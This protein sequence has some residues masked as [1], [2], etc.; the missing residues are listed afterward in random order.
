MNTQTI[1]RRTTW[2]V[3]AALAAALLPWQSAAAEG[4][5]AAAP[6]PEVLPSL[7]QWHPDEGEFTLADRARIVLDGERDGRTA[8]D[9]RRFADELAGGASVVRGRGAARSGDIVLRQDAALKG[10]LG[11]EGYR[12]DVGD[13]M[14]VTAA[15]STG[16]FYGSRTALQLLN[17]DGRAARGSATDVPEYRE[18]GVGVCA[19][20]INVSI[21]WFER[22]LKD[23]ASQKLNQLWIEAK[24]RSDT[25]PASAF[26]GY[27][28]KPQVRTLVALAKKYHVELVPE[29]N[30]PGHMD[31]YLENHPELQLKD[32]DGVASPSRLDISR[33]EALAYYTSLVDEALEVW[34]TRT[35]HM[36]AD[37][38]MI[39]SSYP[40]YPQLQAAATAGFG[41]DATPD[42]LFA[43][44]VNQVDGH[45][46]ADGRSLRI[47][48][49]GLSGRNGVVPLNPDITVEH[50][51]GGGAVQKPSALLA[52]GRPVMNSAYAL[53][54]VRGG[55]TTRTREL[56]E[57]DWTPLRFED[58]TLPAAPENLTG[59]KISLWPDSAAAETENEVEEKTFMPLRFLAQA[60]W[61]GPKP[62]DT[63]A[64][65]EELARRIGHA[66][67]WS[68]TDRAPL[69]D[70]T[71]RLASGPKAL[72][73]G[74]DS[75]VSLVRGTAASWTLTATTDGYYTVRSAAT[76]QCL[77][78]VRGKKYL[79]APLEVGAELSL[80]ACSA[81]ART[82][83]WQ[84][85]PVAGALV[86]RNA[87]SQ[88]RLTE[89]A[90]DGAA[91]QTTGG[92][93]LTAR[94]A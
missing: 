50:W 65:F 29:I 46:R 93:P 42:D 53:Y 18:R 34:D 76:G 82:Q 40:E 90:P 47:W 13:R 52:E 84:L 75:A 5:P 86:L 92:T 32:R 62:S 24:V 68:N 54:L 78:A 58:E 56:Y 27:Y 30:S 67:G 55:Y 66:P 94:T 14:T 48:N 72:T 6:P 57:S 64:G 1:G 59:A 3:V 16:V 28:T 35:W 31:T 20:Y 73:P 37:E 85:D 74:A 22:L 12:L 43:D 79:G 80:G 91:V 87:V 4:S 2:A 26:W 49:D 7:R 44:F 69:A 38:Y 10:S 36:G 88:L 51:L 11:P 17:D 60:T 81:T 83:R 19:C 63:Y 89:R 25:D 45:V 39:G 71:Y 23:M 9:A 41:A 15:T 33:P 70:G 77:D 21:P 61:G 8:A